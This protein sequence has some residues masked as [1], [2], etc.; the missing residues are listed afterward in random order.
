MI[1]PQ[2]IIQK[3]PVF[4]SEEEVKIEVILEETLHKRLIRET[5]HESREFVSSIFIV[6]GAEAA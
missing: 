6:K 3:I 4:F 5:A 2:N 1:F